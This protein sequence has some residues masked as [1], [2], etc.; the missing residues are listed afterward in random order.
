MNFVNSKFRLYEKLTEQRANAM[1]KT[2]WFNELYSRMMHA[3]Q[4]RYP[5]PEPEYR[6]VAEPSAH[7]G[8]HE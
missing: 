3:E 7:Y 8:S 2:L 4:G 5:I 1:L 6:M